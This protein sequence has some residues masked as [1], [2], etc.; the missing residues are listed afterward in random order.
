MK[1]KKSNLI[2]WVKFNSGRQFLLV[3]LIG[4]RG[5]HWEPGGHEGDPH[6]GVGHAA[7]PAQG[8]LQQVQELPPHLRRQSG[9]QP[10]QE[11]HPGHVLTEQI[12]LWGEKDFV[13]RACTTVGDYLFNKT[14]GATESSSRTCVHRTDWACSR[15]RIGYCSVA[16]PNKLNLDPD[17]GL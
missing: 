17:P 11:A 7:G 2:F 4:G 12:Q 6:Q 10:L 3:V 5:E 15:E 16:D 14:N 8:D 13:M 9:L 1:R